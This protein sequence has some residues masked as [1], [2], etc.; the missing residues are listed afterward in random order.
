MRIDE[1]ERN[2][3]ERIKNEEKSKA[4]DEIYSSYDKSANFIAD[5]EQRKQQLTE[6][7]IMR[8]KEAPKE[9]KGKEKTKE[10]GAQITKQ[11]NKNDIFDDEDLEFAKEDA[12]DDEYEIIQKK[13]PSKRIE[14]SIQA[15]KAAEPEK[16]QEVVL[17]EPRKPGN[18]QMEFTEKMYPHMAARETHH[19]DPPFPKIGNQKGSVSAGCPLSQ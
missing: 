18:I 11:P 6:Y 9:K 19:T 15:K 8:A 10:T 7:E 2:E 14:Q 13:E 5:E 17:P 1:L 16:V 12:D 4:L 3:I